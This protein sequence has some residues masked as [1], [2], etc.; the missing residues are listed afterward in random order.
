MNILL[1][2]DSNFLR[3]AIARVLSRA[4]HNVTAVADGR[5]ALDAAQT[6]LPAIIL[7][8]MMLPGLD[9]MGVMKELQENASTAQIPIIVLTGLSQ[10][11]ESRLKQAGATAYIEK[12]SLDLQNQEGPLMN[13]IASVIQKAAG[14][15]PDLTPQ[16][17]N[18]KADTEI[19][20]GA[21]QVD[22]PGR[23]Q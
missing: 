10:K 5:K 21:S 7:L 12:A 18:S 17:A 13:A 22:G 8:D 3:T 19:S 6:S 20:Q 1:V 4:G 15:Q 2:E 23:P 11:N 16:I 9:G 14:K